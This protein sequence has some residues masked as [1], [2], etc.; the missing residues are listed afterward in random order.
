MKTGMKGLV[1]LAAIAAAAQMM[2]MGPPPSGFAPA[3]R[4]TAPR[5]SATYR[6]NGT[7][8]VARRR[9]QIE[10]KNGRADHPV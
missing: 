2:M 9:R 1:S 8:E 7:R 4:R 3:P 10:K 6:P 5:E